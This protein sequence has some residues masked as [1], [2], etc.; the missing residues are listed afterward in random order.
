MAIG[1]KKPNS[2]RIRFESLHDSTNELKEMQLRG[3]LDQ[4]SNHITKG[5]IKSGSAR[6][7]LEGKLLFVQRNIPNS[8]FDVVYCLFTEELEITNHVKKAFQSIISRGGIYSSKR[9]FKEMIEL[10]GD[11]QRLT[12]FK[13]LSFESALEQIDNF[14]TTNIDVNQLGRLVSLVNH[15]EDLDTSILEKI[16]LLV[17]EMM[18]ELETSSN[19]EDP[20]EFLDAAFLTAS[21]YEKVDTFH[22][23]MELYKKIIPLAIENERHNLETACRIRLC[24]IYRDNFPDSSELIL[25]QLDEVTQQDLSEMTKANLEAY[26]LFKGH[27]Y[28]DQ[29]NQ[30]RAK[31]YYEMAIQVTSGGIS[32]PA[33]ITQAYAQL[34]AMNYQ[35]YYYSE[36][37]RQY[38]TASAIAFSMGDVMLSDLH[39][40]NASMPDIYGSLSLAMTALTIRMDDNQLEAEYKS[41]EA[42]K[43]LVKAYVHNLQGDPFQ[44]MDIT[45]K[46]LAYCQAILD[47][48][49]KKRKNLRVI[50]MIRR[51]I[52]DLSWQRIEPG[53]EEKRISAVLREIDRNL[54]LPAPVF[55]LLSRDGRLII[56]GKI[57]YEEGWIEADIKGVILS[58]IIAAITSLIPEVSDKNS[59]L[60][61]IDAGNFQ[62]ILEQGENIIAV[63]L[64]DRVNSAFRRRLADIQRYIEK[65]YKHIL[66]NWDGTLAYFNDLVDLVEHTFAPSVLLNLI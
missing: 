59:S 16:Y 56:M 7:F 32:S 8:E 20:D 50:R 60:K 24:A 52:D 48:P 65:E 37:S 40:Q 55:M 28:Y 23:A 36:A 34:A 5:R 21:Y 31:V 30:E 54:P 45:E 6:K 26:Y 57:D 38:L 61:T 46:I 51:L 14:D 39:L 13:S 3:L 44:M 11:E 1:Q 42:L 35:N 27:A 12:S 62:I 64:V 17:Y 25:A 15:A 47:R 63:L 41:W 2:N 22:L 4:I 49:G 53:G 10:L 58:G 33:L 9:F 18:Q 43:L 29:F 66:V 19:I